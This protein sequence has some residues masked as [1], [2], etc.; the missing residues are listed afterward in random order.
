MDIRPPKRPEQGDYAAA[1]A[2]QL[3]KPAKLNPFHIATQIANHYAK[4]DFVGA[5]EVVHPGFINFRLDADWL[6]QQ[7]EAIIAAGDDPR[8]ISARARRR[9]SSSSAPTRPDRSPSGAAGAA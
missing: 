3:S 2:M 6:R 4:P 5:V 8:W 9:R 7:T 1:V